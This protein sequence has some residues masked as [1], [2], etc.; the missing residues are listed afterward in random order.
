MPEA[1][2]E[3]AAAE[4]AVVALAVVALAVVALAEVAL[5][6]AVVALAEVALVEAALV[7]AESADPQVHS[8][9]DW[10]RA[11]RSRHRRN[12]LPASALRMRTIRQEVLSVG[13]S[14]H[15]KRLPTAAVP[16]Y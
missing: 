15:I 4:L 14:P 7:E 2:A 13:C 3:E 12:P 16:Y 1:E 8:E 9:A 11:T 6:L 5:A 10:I